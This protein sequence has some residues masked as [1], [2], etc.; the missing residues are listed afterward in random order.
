MKRRPRVGR[1]N[2]FLRKTVEGEC[3]STVIVVSHSLREVLPD[4]DTAIYEERGAT[5]ITTVDA[6][7]GSKSNWI[8]H[9]YWLSEPSKNNNSYR[10]LD[11]IAAETVPINDFLLSCALRSLSYCRS[12]NTP[13]LLI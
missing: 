3:D 12:K 11:H 6:P 5:T 10:G 7:R 2:F 8:M 4:Q 9:E 13:L 1:F